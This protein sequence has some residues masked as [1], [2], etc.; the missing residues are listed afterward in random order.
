[1]CRTR[2]SFPDAAPGTNTQGLTLYC[3]GAD[4]GA[5]LSHS[6]QYR[7]LKY[8]YTGSGALCRAQPG[9]FP[10]RR[11]R[12]PGLTPVGYGYRSIAYIVSKCLE[13]E[14]CEPAG[15]AALLQRDR[16]GGNHGDPGQ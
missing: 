6:D 3:Q 16:R 15:R 2:S 14:A 11:S 8:S 12:R 5:L 9:L 7:G 13:V 1:M 10:V 4:K